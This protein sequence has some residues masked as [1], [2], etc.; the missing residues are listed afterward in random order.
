[1]LKYIIKRIIFIPVILLAV[2]V[3][4]FA[5]VNL[6]PVDPATSMLPS[7]ATQE[8]RDALH[9]ELGLDQPL[10]AQYFSY[11][12]KLLRGDLGKSWYYRVPVIEEIRDKIPITA[13]L[14]IYSTIV[15]VLIGLPL[16]VICAVKQYSAADEI[17]N[18]ISKILGSMPNFWMA[19]MLML[20]F[21][22]K[23]KWLPLYGFSSWQHWILPVAT[24]SIQTI[25]TY[26]RI[27]RSTM[28][29]CIREDY[30]RTARAKGCKEGA[31][32][33]GHALKNA[34]LPIIT[35]TGQMFASM[36]GGAI[37]VESVFSIPGLGSCVVHAVKV[38]DIPLTMSC[39]LIISAIFLI[40]S[41]IIDLLYVVADPR[42]KATFETAKRRRRGIEEL[43]D[44]DDEE[45]L[46]DTLELKGV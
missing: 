8:D 43:E 17:L 15:T 9:R 4:I 3:I 2:S 28:L 30:V 36:M 18:G 31:V 32:I 25:G 44:D 39:V 27:A 6:S 46:D 7:T 13:E 23:L 11:M 45:E 33:F 10:Y 37:V 38:K 24:I 41:L 12:S 29:D 20:L 1:M 19:L 5:L 35:F 21:A 22:V 16:G 40:A 14:A 34:L 42:V 26:L